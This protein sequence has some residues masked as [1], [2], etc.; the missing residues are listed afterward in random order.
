MYQTSHLGSNLRRW[1]CHP[2]RRSLSASMHLGIDVT[3]IRD[4]AGS[5]TLVFPGFH[6]NLV[7]T[8]SQEKRSF[9]LHAPRGRRHLSSGPR[10]YTAVRFVRTSGV[11]TQ[12]QATKSFGFYAPRGRRHTHPGRSGVGDSRVPGYHSNVG[13]HSIP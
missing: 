7:V 8:Q 6:Y 1:L 11:V 5:G 2:R 4:A 9:G 12:S 3:R 13:S 10:E